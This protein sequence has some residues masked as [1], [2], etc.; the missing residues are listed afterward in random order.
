MTIAAGATYCR[1]PGCSGTI[2]D[3]G[4]GSPRCLLCGRGPAEAV[5]TA[6]DFYLADLAA[7][8]RAP[9]G[10]SG[11]LMRSCIDESE[12]ERPKRPGVRSRKWLAWEGYEATA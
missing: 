2:I 9:P 11:S 7:M 5:G 12:Y 3:F 1:R 10:S 6:N 4:D 8:M